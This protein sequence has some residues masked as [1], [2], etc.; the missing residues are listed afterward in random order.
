VDGEYKKLIVEL[1]D[2]LSE[3]QLRYI[4]KLIKAFL[5]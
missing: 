2:K 3:K 4:Y 1:L 5:D